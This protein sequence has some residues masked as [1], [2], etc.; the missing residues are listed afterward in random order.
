MILVCQTNR[1]IDESWFF[2]LSRRIV[3]LWP[4]RRER[5]G[6]VEEIFENLFVFFLKKIG[7]VLHKIFLKS[8]KVQKYTPPSPKNTNL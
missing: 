1:S 5:A 4:S 3:D 8:K 2:W 6:T 7:Q